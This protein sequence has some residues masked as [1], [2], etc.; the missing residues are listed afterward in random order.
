M[1]GTAIITIIMGTARMIDD[2]NLRA[3]PF[4]DETL[5]EDEVGAGDAAPDREPDLASANALPL[6]VWLSPSFPVG[7]FAFS[8]GIEWA[9]ETGDVKDKDSTIAWIGA[10]LAH[11][12]LRNDTI[13]AA[14][15]WRAVRAQDAEALREVAELALALAGSRERHLET[16]AQG[17]AFVTAIRS[18]WDHPALNWAWGRLSGDVAYPVAVAT[19][20]A[21]H[22]IPLRAMLEAFS[23][24]LVQTLVSAT[25]RLSALGHSDGQRVVAALLPKTQKLVLE[26][27]HATLDDIGGAA[28]GSDIAALRHETQY[29]RLFRS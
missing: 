5:R 3:V 18:A 1:P 12:A 9:V 16:T 29:T 22:G 11:G 13:L 17:N 27:E 6:M 23:L 26:V 15:A 10:L 28:F 20:A 24:A 21:G 25:I 14:A 8:H 2:A 19:A 4:S 7:S